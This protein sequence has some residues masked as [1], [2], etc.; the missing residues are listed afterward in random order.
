MITY[1]EAEIR[2]EVIKAMAHPVRLIVIELLKDNDKSF[3]ELLEYF[4]IDKSTLSKHISILKTI[5]IVTS[6]KKGTESIFHLQVPCVTQFF[7]CVTAVIEDKIKQQ[8]SC[9]CSVG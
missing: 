9:L 4:D 7:T 2:S 1:K 6:Q 3:S 5:G 8:Q